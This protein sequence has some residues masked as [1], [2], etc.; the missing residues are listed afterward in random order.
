M[1]LEDRPCWLYFDL[2]YSKETNPE[3]EPGVAMAAFEETL[4]AFCQDVLGL[5]LDSSSLLVLESS[6]PQKF[7]KHVLAH[8]LLDKDGSKVP[9]AFANNAQAG[10]LV[11]ELMDY[12]RKHREGSSSKYLFVRPPKADAA[13]TRE[14]AMIDESVY[15][16][17]RS[18]RLL[19]QSKFAKTRRLDLEQTASR[20]FF[21]GQWPLHPMLA[22]VQT[23]VTFVPFDTKMF[24]H[25]IIPESFGHMD[26]KAR[27][28]R[29]SGSVVVR[30]SDGKVSV[31]QQDPLL[32]HLVKEWDRVRDEKEKG[33]FPPTCVQT[34]VEL[35]RRFSTVTLSNNRFCECKGSSHVSNNVYMVV[36]SE[37]RCFH[38]TLG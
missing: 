23:M 10:L 29:H 20:R 9:L 6:T 4:A 17:N 24:R 7:S 33:P 26:M 2:E 36:D 19:F 31:A 1:I 16:R 28:V 25:E 21:Q 12:A 37:L 30:S 8:R 18:F 35:D 32:N 15:S 34:Y 27:Q 38:Q 13:D 5:A 14:T 3:L 22:L 11:G